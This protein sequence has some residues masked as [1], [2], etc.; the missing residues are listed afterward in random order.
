MH[1]TR[2]ALSFTAALLA[3]VLTVVATAPAVAGQSL[4]E[5]LL[6][7]ADEEATAATTDPAGYVADQGTEEGL[8]EDVNW[9]IAYGCYARAVAE[10]ETGISTPESDQCEGYERAIGIAP[11]EDVEAEEAVAEAEELD[12]PA[13]AEAEA[14]AEDVEATVGRIGDDPGRAGDEAHG[15]LER[16]QRAAVRAVHAVIYTLGAGTGLA[17]RGIVGGASLS[18]HGFLLAAQGLL[19]AKGAAVGSVQD[20]ARTTGAAVSDGAS[21]LQAAVERM[22]DQLLGQPPALEP[23]RDPLGSLTTPLP[24]TPADDLLDPVPN[25]LQL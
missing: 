23:K 12:D 21:S 25:E 6:A 10:D 9:T 5:P 20:A 4:E 22:V 17:M 13:R 16:T 24:E 18:G 19:D 14:L 1:P 3:I 11:E 2:L 7:K 15:L 8:A